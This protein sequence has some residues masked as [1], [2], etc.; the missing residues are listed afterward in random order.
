MRCQAE[1]TATKLQHPVNAAQSCSLIEYVL[2]SADAN[3]QID[4]LVRDSVQL[5]GIVHLKRAI[6]SPR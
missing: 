3:H 6:G 4:R 5:L 1:E 2:E